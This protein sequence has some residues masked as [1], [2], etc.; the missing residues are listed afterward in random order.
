MDHVKLLPLSSTKSVD[1]AV[2]EAIK[3][4]EEDPRF[5]VAPGCEITSDTLIDNVKALVNA[6][7][8]FND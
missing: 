2:K 4:S 8:T 3:A 7:K 1:N 6:T 5:I